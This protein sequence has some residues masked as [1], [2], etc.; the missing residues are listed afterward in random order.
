MEWR[1]WHTKSWLRK[2]SGSLRQCEIFSILQEAQWQ[3]NLL[4]TSPS[5]PLSSDIS[6]CIPSVYIFIHYLVR[7]HII[8]NYTPVWLL[9][10][11]DSTAIIS[12]LKSITLLVCLTIQKHN[13]NKFGCIIINFF[14]LPLFINITFFCKF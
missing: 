12:I 8:L 2:Q 10:P 5:L 11:I 7:S 3:L 1:K 13:F 6:C 4:S 9:A 14:Q